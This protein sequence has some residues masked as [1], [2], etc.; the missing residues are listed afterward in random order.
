MVKVFCGRCEHYRGSEK[1]SN[2]KSTAWMDASRPKCA[3][4]KVAQ[5][6]QCKYYEPNAATR[7]REQKFQ[8]EI[9][10]LS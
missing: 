5:D 4:G 3:I 6:Y 2:P 9:K 10:C 1:V 8:Q 7:L